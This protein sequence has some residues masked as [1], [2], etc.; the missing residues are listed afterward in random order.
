VNT[1]TIVSIDNQA[2]VWNPTAQR[3]ELRNPVPSGKVVKMV[4]RT[5]FNPGNAQYFVLTAC[6]EYR[7]QPVAA[8]PAGAGYTDYDKTVDI[9]PFPAQAPCSV[10]ATVL[11]VASDAVYFTTS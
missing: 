5:N 1:V 3:Y 9:G 4:V 2:P 8:T 10:Q 7:A 6:A 11:S